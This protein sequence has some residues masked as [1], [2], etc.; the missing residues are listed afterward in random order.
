MNQNTKYIIAYVAWPTLIGLVLAVILITFV[1]PL[2]IKS[3]NSSAGID[4]S[5]PQSTAAANTVNP[6]WSGPV[7]YANAVRRASPSVVNISSVRIESRKVHPFF[8]DPI[9][10]QLFNSA[11]LQYQQRLQSTL[12]SG[13][14]INEDGILLTN[15][16][17][18]R[19][20]EEITVYLNDGREAVAIPVGA[21]DESDL[22]VL[23]IELDNLVPITIGMPDEAQVGD[24]VLAIGN[25][26]GIGQSVSQ[27]IISAKNRIDLDNRGLQNFM[28][29]D[30][31]IN[32]GNSGGALVDAYGNLLGI[33]TLLV[34][35]NSSS[36]GIGFAIPA[37]IALAVVED[38]LEFGRVVRGWL[39]LAA[40]PLTLREAKLLNLSFTDG[41]L[42]RSVEAQSPAAQAGLKPGDV[43]T[44][45]ND[46]PAIDHDQM[47]QQIS[48][49]N[50]GEPL[51][52][53]VWRN[54][55][56]Y[57]VTAVV[58]EKP[59]SPAS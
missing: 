48:G 53:E 44:S 47:S 57:K 42:V 2:Q 8:N 11:P 14:I 56:P 30:A 33:N 9:I 58:G 45:I 40:T 7:S 54:G 1:P 17:V 46:Q 15:R 41:W 23:K 50:P 10:R 16:H 26:Y 20:A 24:V 21:D 37:N 6:E 4:Q 31:A 36:S 34:N 29:T 38:I 5:P 49:T 39:G 52:I 18:I 12:G 22:A 32:P 13:V 59:D 43:I 3:E 55:R 27:G 51:E 19:G 25:P 28:Q 35:D